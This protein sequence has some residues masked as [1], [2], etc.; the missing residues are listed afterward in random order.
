MTDTVI[1]HNAYVDGNATVGGYVRIGG[2]L[3]VDGWLDAP[4][5]KNAAKGLFLSADQ[6]KQ[7]YPQ[8]LAGWWALV[9]E[10]LPA[11]VYAVRDGKWI[12]TGR[13]AGS[14]TVEASGVAEAVGAETAARRQ[15]DEQLSKEMESLRAELAALAAN[16]GKNSADIA[17][18]RT[19]TGILAFGGFVN[20]RSSS[21]GMG[22][23][24]F[25]RD[26]G[27][28]LQNNGGTWTEPAGYNINNHAR[29]DVLFRSANNLY[30][31]VEGAGG[32][33]TLR[34]L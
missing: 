30:Q 3:R 25:C 15:A 24:V 33:Y 18:H 17:A 4:N 6:L 13:S 9:G 22:T 5:V 20:S 29:Y 10:A 2:S 21:G 1:S 8:P 23:V 14:I 28:F 32:I 34:A 16:V 7:N 26:E 12:A 19:E 31:A 27:L 11:D